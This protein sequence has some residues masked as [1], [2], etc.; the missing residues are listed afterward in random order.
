M[1]NANLEEMAVVG[2]QGQ[3]LRN[4]EGME[5]TCGIL[6]GAGGVMQARKAGT[7]RQRPSTRQG[8]TAKNLLYL[9]DF[10]QT[11]GVAFATLGAKSQLLQS[12]GTLL[13]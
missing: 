12:Q 11:R 3:H 6:R 9:H 2:A 7:S 13:R 1:L 5:R 4:I 10:P 8:R